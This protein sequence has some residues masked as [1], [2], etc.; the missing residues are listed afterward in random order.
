MAM[1]HTD[2]DAIVVGAGFS[3]KRVGVIGIGLSGIQ[4]IPLIAEQ[5]ATTVVFQRTANYSIPAGYGPSKPEKLAVKERYQEYCEEA[6]WTNVGVV[7]KQPMEFA[8]AVSA[9]ERQQRYEEL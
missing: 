1:Q 5:A 9:E 7:G 8:F 2:L 4:S 3:G 6:R